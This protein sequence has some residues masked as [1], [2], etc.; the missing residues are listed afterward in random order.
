[1]PGKD[2][3][4]TMFNEIS[5]KYDFLNHLLSFGIDRYWRKRLVKELLR[6]HPGH[7]LDI[8]TGT[9]DL[10]IALRKKGEIHVTGV[11]IAGNMIQ[12]GIKKVHATGFSADIE[13]RIGDA[14]HLE[15][16]DAMFDAVMV[17]FGARNFENLGKGL[18]EMKRVLKK[19]GTMMILEFSHPGTFPLR[20]L[21]SLYSRF[22]IPFIGRMFSVY[23]SAYRYLPET[24]AAFPSD[25]AFLQVMQNAGLVNCNFISLSGGIASIYSGT[26]P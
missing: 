16:P 23:P 5:G 2:S 7:V 10:A 15:F 20:Q 21:Y 1:M 6:S 4:R 11:D 26:K 18:T 25:N 13:L 17:A 12:I 22:G 19:N 14:E 3:V 24:V 8:A 9:G